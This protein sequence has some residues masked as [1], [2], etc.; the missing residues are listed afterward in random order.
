MVPLSSKLK[1]LWEALIHKD[2]VYTAVYADVLHD[3]HGK[4]TGARL[5][6][7]VALPIKGLQDS[8]HISR[9]ERRHGGGYTTFENHG[10]GWP[11]KKDKVFSRTQAIAALKVIEKDYAESGFRLTQE[12]PFKS[13]WVNRPATA[14]AKAAKPG[15]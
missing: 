3:V 6:W 4:Q 1:A 2:T 5:H 9:F 12:Q 13:R 11:H 14:P 10:A 7:A 8:Y 15:V